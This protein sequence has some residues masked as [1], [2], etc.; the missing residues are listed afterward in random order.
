MLHLAKLHRLA[1]QERHEVLLD[2]VLRNGRPLPLA[3]RARLSEAGGVRLASLGFALQRGVELSYQPTPAIEALARLT[4]NALNEL[5]DPAGPAGR[6]RPVAAGAQG[7]C[8]AGAIAAALAGLADVL[9]QADSVGGSGVDLSPGLPGR[10]RAAIRAGAYAL[11]EAQGRLAARSLPWRGLVG[12]PLD[13]SL[14][15]WQLCA[16]AELCG[17]RGLVSELVNWP[18]LEQAVERLNLWRN[19]DCAALLNLAQAGA[20]APAWRPARSRPA[21]A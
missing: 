1:E 2:E 11:F 20:S 5:A 19:P 10:I 4:V 14:V 6:E 16:R 9:Q 21:A 13:S 8:G 18:E 12:D 7:P 17:E 15:L 3:A